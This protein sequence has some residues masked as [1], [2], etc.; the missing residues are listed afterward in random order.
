MLN[1][2]EITDIGNYIYRKFKNENGFESLQVGRKNVEGD[3]CLI[4]N[5]YEK[6]YIKYFDQLIKTIDVERIY[7]VVGKPIINKDDDKNTI[8]QVLQNYLPTVQG[9]KDVRR[10]N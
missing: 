4:I 6:D 2:K 7:K 1:K 9:E 5:V 8:K 10:T 3:F